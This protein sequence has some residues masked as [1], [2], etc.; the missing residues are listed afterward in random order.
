MAQ[1]FQIDTSDYLGFQYEEYLNNLMAVAM[2]TPKIYYD[3]RANTLKELKQVVVKTVYDT[4]YN[5]LTKG[6]INGKNTL[7]DSDGNNLVPH[8]P[9]QNA[10]QFAIS[11]S[12]T[13][14]EI[15][16]KALDIILP[17]NHLDV[18]KLKLTQKGEASKI[19]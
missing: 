15:L 8:Y 10:S 5:L 4:Y 2:S 17:S 11:A 19:E 9:Q 13:I 18:A 3:M 7:V 14:N 12:K 6:T 1:N 16:N